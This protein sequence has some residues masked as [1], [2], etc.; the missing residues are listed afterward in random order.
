MGAVVESIIYSTKIVS[1]KSVIDKIEELGFSVSLEQI[2]LID[3]WEYSNHESL[4]KTEIDRINKEIT[5][6]RIVIIEFDVNNKWRCGCHMQRINDFIYETCIWLNTK[7]LEFLDTDRIT[8]KNKKFYD[9]ATEEIVK[10]IAQKKI[11]IACIGVETIV[12]YDD[13]VFN[14]ISLSKNVMRWILPERQLWLRN[15]LHNEI[16]GVHIYSLV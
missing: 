10:I 7:N 13:S 4:N 12:S 15:Y 9:K 3:N 1:F 14:I 16:N 5:N 2:D 6:R 8:I 11:Q